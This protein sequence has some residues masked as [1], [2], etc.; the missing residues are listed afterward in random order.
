[1]LRDPIVTQS[2]TLGV[3][4]DSNL[5]FD[6]HVSAVCKKSFFHLRALRHI[7]SALTDEMAVSIAV[8]LIVTAGL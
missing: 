7:C 1:M 2:N 4:L 6:S 5:T 8:A 3:I